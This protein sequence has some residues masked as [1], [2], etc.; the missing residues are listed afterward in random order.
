MANEGN[1]DENKE[2][3]SKRID[4]FPAEI[5]ATP[6]QATPIQDIPSTVSI[7]DYD[8]AQKQISDKV[9]ESAEKGKIKQV[10]TISILRKNPINATP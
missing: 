7:G 8:K 2:G 4:K 3:N 9:S 5:Q 10:H 6:N 1:R